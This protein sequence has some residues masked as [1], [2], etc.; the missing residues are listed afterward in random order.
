MSDEKKVPNPSDNIALKQAKARVKKLRQIL[1]K[2]R[3]AYHVL[4]KPVMEDSV[5][6]TLKNEL[7]ELEK[8]FPTLKTSDSPTQRIGGEP[9]AKFEKVVHV[10]PMLSLDDAFSFEELKTWQERDQR[11]LKTKNSFAYFSEVKVVGFAV[12]RGNGKIGEDVTLNLKTIESI[13]LILRRE[14][15]YFKEASHGRFEV[16]GEV[17]MS[18][19]AFAKLNSMRKKKRL[20]LFANPRNAAAGSIR[21]LNPK[22]AASR[23][24]DFFAY[25]ILTDIKFNK[26]H[27]AHD[28]ACDLGFSVIPLNRPCQNLDEVEKF[29]IDLDKQRKKLNYWIDGVV[30]VIDDLKT[31]NS[32]GVAGKAPRAMIAY[33]FAPEEVTTILED[34]IFNIGR[35]GMVN[36]VAILEPVQVAGTTVSRATLHNEDQIKKLDIKIGDTVVVVKAGD[37]IPKVMRK[38]KDLRPRDAVDIKFPRTCPGCGGKLIK[39]GAYWY[40]PHKNCFTIKRRGIGHFVSKGAFDIEGLGPQIIISLMEQG[41][42][43]KSADLFDLKE[44]DLEPLERFAEKSAQNLVKSIQ[45]KKKIDLGRLLYSLGI[46]HVGEQTAYDLANYFKTLDRIKRATLEDLAQ[47]GNIGEIVAASVFKY[48]KDKNDLEDLAELLKK[49]Q[50]VEF[51]IKKSKITGKSFCITGSLKLMSRDQA[52]EKIRELGGEWHSDVTEDLSYLIVGND[53]GSKLDRAKTLGIKWISEQS[54]LSLIK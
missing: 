32:L 21:Q 6:D 38:I 35:T 23:E 5:F 47:V 15:K 19:T 46:R 16:R 37:I 11:F 1:D 39:K 30:V 34:V 12:S 26:H 18:G 36:P 45:E 2:A 4:D 53:P 29:K 52:K 13:P 33:K 14:S 48:F 24:L 17:Y 10:K 54:F 9:L 50:V 7:E 31:F 49:V 43:K 28:I 27:E 41:L 8:I 20:A 25:D 3:H 40:C 51:E 44:S 42:V 22:I